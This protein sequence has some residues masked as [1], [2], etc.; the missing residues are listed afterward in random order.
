[1]PKA[2]R[3]SRKASKP[4]NNRYFVTTIDGR[5]EYHYTVILIRNNGEI[6]WIGFVTAESTL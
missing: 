4:N 3:L 2:W 6:T 1:M 5:D